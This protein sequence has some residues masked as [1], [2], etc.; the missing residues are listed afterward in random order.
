VT[1]EPSGGECRAADGYCITCSD[2]GIPMRVV[3]A[4]DVVAL[5]RDETRELH[6]VAIDLVA[7]VLAGERVLVHAGVAIGHL[8]SIPTHPTREHS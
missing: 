3:S 8:E 2:E 6:E 7:P 4:D 5:C 1:A